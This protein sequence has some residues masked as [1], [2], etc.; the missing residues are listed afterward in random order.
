MY[1]TNSFAAS[2]INW[3][4]SFGCLRIS[5]CTPV[6]MAFGAPSGWFFVDSITL[7]STGNNYL[8]FVNAV[9]RSFHRISLS[10]PVTVGH[11]RRWP[12]S[13][14]GVTNWLLPKFQHPARSPLRRRQAGKVILAA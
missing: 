3:S 1:E 6:G 9:L 7:S 2:C 5:F 12:L 14:S 11:G 13:F 8:A 10:A 4:T